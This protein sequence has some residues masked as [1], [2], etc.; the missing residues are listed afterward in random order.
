MISFTLPGDAH[1]TRGRLVS[2]APGDFVPL[3]LGG[4]P[5]EAEPE[6]EFH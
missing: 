2:R 6:A 1:V 5:R 4:N 3:R